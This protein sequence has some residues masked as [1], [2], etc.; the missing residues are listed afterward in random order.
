MAI[1]SRSRYL[2]GIDLGTSNTA[3]AYAEPAGRAHT[4]QSGVRPSI[5]IFSVPQ[6]IAPGEVQARPL[7]PSFRYHVAET[8]LSEADRQLGL[9]EPLPELPRAVLGSLAQVLG[10]RVPGRLVA[11]AKSW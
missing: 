4:A 2:I 10:S 6:L 11:S 5:C 1:D 3:L 7:L 9:P 8:E